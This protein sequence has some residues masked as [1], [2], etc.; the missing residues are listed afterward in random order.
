MADFAAYSSKKVRMHGEK[1]KS[2][3]R[4]D[5]TLPFVSYLILIP[6]SRQLTPEELGRSKLQRIVPSS[7]RCLYVRCMSCAMPSL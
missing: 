7:T 5:S 3:C 1:M 6:S 2:A 4:L